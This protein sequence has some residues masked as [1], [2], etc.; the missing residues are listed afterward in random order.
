[1]KRLT[2]SGSKRDHMA[3]NANRTDNHATDRHV[4]KIAKG[5]AEISH[6]PTSSVLFARHR[7]ADPIAETL[8]ANQVLI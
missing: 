3:A 6:W 1:M 4:A 5:L 7:A 2:G 8:S